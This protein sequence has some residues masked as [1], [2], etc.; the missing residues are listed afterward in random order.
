M[1]MRASD[2]CGEPAVVLEAIDVVE[3]GA[4]AGL[5]PMTDDIL[6]AEIGTADFDLALRAARAPGSER[7]TYVI[8][9]RATDASGHGATS[10]ATVTVPLAR[11]ARRTGPG[12]IAS[13]GPIRNGCLFQYVR[14]RQ[15]HSS[16]PK[17]KCRSQI[18]LTTS[19]T[20]QIG[21]TTYASW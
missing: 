6:G 16:G 9:Y 18:G 17:R 15:H 8:R 3:S 5:P 4:V 12:Q 1:S 11:G 21:R 13:A 2:I 14:D 10:E 20:T 7:R 19:C